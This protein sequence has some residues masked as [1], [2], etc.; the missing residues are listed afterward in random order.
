[1][2]TFSIS[3]TARKAQSSGNGSAGPFSFAFQVNAEAEV[4]VF[5]DTTLKTLSTHYTVSLS[6]DG[7]GSVSFTSNNFPTSS[8]TITIMGDA[9]LS[10]TSVYTSGGNITAAAL[11]S[12]FDTNVMVQQQQQEVLSRTVRA[13]VDDA[14]SVDLTLPNKDARKGKVLGFNATSGNPEVTTQVTG[15]AVNVSTVSVGGSAT[16]SVALSGGTATFALGIPTGATGATGATGQAGGGLANIVSDTTPQLGGNL[17][18]NGKDL[19]TTSNATIDLAP[20]GTG[21]VV[22]R[23][24]TNSGA[25]VFNCSDNS[26]GQKIYAQPHSA[27]VTNNLMLPAGASSTLVSLVSADTLTNKTLTS[28]KV[29][30]NV[31]ITATSTEINKLAGVGTLKQAG[32]ESIWVPAAAM[33][34][35]T[36]NGCSAITQVETTALRPDLKVLDFA[37]AADDFAQFAI[38][39]PKKWNLGTITYQPFWTVT[40]TNT[41]T[42]VWQL[43][44]IA[45]SSDDTINT[46]FGTLVATAALAHSG[47]SNDLMVSAESGAVTI[48]GSPADNDQCFFQINNDTSASGQTGVVRL[49]GIKLFFTTDAANDA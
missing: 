30:E 48:A 44:G 21:T 24:N 12:D 5:V 31:A 41:G 32:K 35:S 20:H 33:Y 29:N 43:G 40:G 36:T 34:A 3:A 17:D 9:P 4:D 1:M 37:A 6:G 2:A 19:V 26:H 13:P 18:M 25:I 23:G 38:S 14:A 39:F 45:V 7:T 27:S 11:E 49:L 10:R 28:P 47:T 46:A 16:A 8:Q 42:V 15:A 22:V